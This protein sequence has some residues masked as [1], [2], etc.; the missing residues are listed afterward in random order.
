MSSEKRSFGPFADVPAEDVKRTGFICHGC[1]RSVERLAKALPMMVPRMMFYA[2][3]CGT[4]AVWED[5]RQP[6]GSRH[7]RMNIELLKRSGAGLL[8]FNGRRPL[9]PDFS[10]IN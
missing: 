5:E 7:W 3:I 8:I 1:R 9:K 10:G 2:C 6:C 4:V